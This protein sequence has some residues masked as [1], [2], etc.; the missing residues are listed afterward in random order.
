MDRITDARLRCEMAIVLPIMI[1]ATE[2]HEY[3][4]QA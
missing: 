1:P 3:L 2:R 4:K